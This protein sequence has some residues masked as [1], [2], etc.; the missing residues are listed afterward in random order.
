M[1]SWADAGDNNGSNTTHYVWTG[2]RLTQTTDPV[3]RITSYSYDNLGDIIS[4]VRPGPNSGTVTDNLT[5]CYWYPSSTQ[6]GSCPTQGTNAVADLATVVA[7]AGTVD[8]RTSTFSYLSD[9]LNAPMRTNDGL[10]RSNGNLQAVTQ[11]AGVPEARTTNFSYYQLG[12]VRTI[13]DAN[14][15]VTT[16]GDINA[17]DQGY[18]PSGQPKMITD[19]IGQ[20]K[21]F[22]YNTY[23]LP[24]TI[25]NRNGSQMQMSY[26]ERD[27]LKT[28]TVVFSDATKNRTTRT[29]YDL[30]GNVA[31]VQEPKGV[32]AGDNSFTTTSTFDQT[33]NPIQVQDPL[34]NKQTTTYYDSGNKATV[35]SMNGNASGATAANFTTTWQYYPDNR[36]SQVSAP[37]GNAGSFGNTSYIYFRDGKASTVTGPGTSSGGL[38]VST[39]TWNNAGSLAS[40]AQTTGSSPNTTFYCYDAVGNTIYTR[41]PNGGTASPACPASNDASGGAFVTRS[42]F[43]HVNQLTSS[44]QYVADNGQSGLQALTSS[45]TFDA[46][47]NQTTVSQPTGQG[48]KLVTHTQY[49]KLNRIQ[50]T[51]DPTNPGHYS[52]FQYKPEGQ[53]TLRQDFANGTLL[54]TTTQAYNDNNALQSVD[55]LNNSAGTHLTTLYYDSTQ[56]DKQS[57][58]DLNGNSLRADT[59]RS[60]IAASAIETYAMAFDGRDKIQTYAATAKAALT[61]GSDVSRTQTYSYDPNGNLT[62]RQYPSQNTSYAYYPSN[63]LQ[64][65]TDPRGKQV[66]YNY[67]LGGQL[68]SQTIHPDV[69]PITVSAT[70]RQSGLLSTMTSSQGTITQLCY[71]GT[72]AAPCGGSTAAISYD[73]NNNKLSEPVSALQQT[74]A[75]KS[76]TASYAYDQLNRLT[77]YVSPWTDSSSRTT[78]SSY[79]LDDAGNIIT[80]TDNTGGTVKST[81]STYPNNRLA[82]S[83][84]TGAQS[85]SSAFTYDG[86]G[87]E[88][89]RK[90]SGANSETI[91]YDAAGH[92]ASHVSSVNAPDPTA[93]TASAGTVSYVYDGGGRILKRIETGPPQKSSLFFYSG[94]SSTSLLEECDL[95]GATQMR[96]VPSAS[97]KAVEQYDGIASETNGWTWYGYDSRGNVANRTDDAGKVQETKAYGP[98]GKDDSNGSSQDVSKTTSHLGFQGAWRDPQSAQYAIGPRTFDANAGRFT[99]ADN[100]ANA[101]SDLSLAGDSLTGNRYLYAGANPAGYIDSGYDPVPAAAC[102]Q[103]PVC[104]AGYSGGGHYGVPPPPPSWQGLYDLGSQPPGP[105]EQGGHHGS[106][107]ATSSQSGGA[108]SPSGC[109]LGPIQCSLGADVTAEGGNGS[110]SLG[111][112]CGYDFWT[113]PDANNRPALTVTCGDVTPRSNGGWV[114]GGFVGAGAHMTFT[115]AQQISDQLGPFHNLNL[116]GFFV[117][118]HVSQ[119]NYPSFYFWKA[120]YNLTLNIGP[121]FGYSASAYD[122]TTSFPDANGFSQR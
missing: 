34:G 26:T 92:T 122:T 54:R 51:D 98:Y 119:G 95:G 94:P 109:G 13:S 113:L 55:V 77:S 97:G 24:T 45:F 100:Y 74:G 31:T 115:S 28:S 10:T 38:S 37:A 27:Q 118:V 19:S 121:G 82:T 47:G 71:G 61:G 103:D 25:A 117:G 8:Q 39:A 49:N 104:A 4:V 59:I 107:G 85:Y 87:Q 101:N 7:A 80:Q 1:T 22:Q 81:T 53:Q 50:Q 88:T 14:G 65:L 106:S 70:Y 16:Y 93:T 86:L 18:D 99:T 30:N 72:A 67:E 48:G 5:Y 96:Y 11:A 6:T 89:A 43:D 23:G 69:N 73:A 111:A 52:I 41:A 110:P 17:A 68:Q 105:P 46:V 36:I 57:G 79:T 91:T 9:G 108:R 64:T 42:Y 56:T 60:D 114:V 35:V 40:E 83:N 29:T 33:D 90:V 62:S 20:A 2:N 58:Y 120:T 66:N 21:S 116:N 44:V 112:T 3:G 75:P 63:Q 32:A 12:Q 84:V 76:G 15:N 78:T 102:A